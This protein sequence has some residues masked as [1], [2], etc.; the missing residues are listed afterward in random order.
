MLIFAEYTAFHC[1][2][3]KAIRGYSFFCRLFSLLSWFSYDGS[4]TDP[5]R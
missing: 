1:A 5:C 3:N 2:D 4:G